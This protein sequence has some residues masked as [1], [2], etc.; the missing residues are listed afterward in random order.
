MMIM[1]IIVKMSVFVRHIKITIIMYLF[2][3]DDTI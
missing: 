3:V 2:K 1:K